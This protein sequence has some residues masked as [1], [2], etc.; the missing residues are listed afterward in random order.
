LAFGIYLVGLWHVRT[1]MSDNN[2]G[3]FTIIF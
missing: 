3:N 2:V 1:Y